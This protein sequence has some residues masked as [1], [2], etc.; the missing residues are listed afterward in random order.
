MRPLPTALS[1]L[2]LAAAGLVFAASARTSPVQPT[3]PAAGEPKESEKGRSQPRTAAD[4]GKSLMEG[5]KATPGCLGVETAQTMS[6]KVVIFT[7]FEN[8]KAV[9]AWYDSPAHKRVMRAFFPDRDGPDV[10]MKDIAED[11][12]PILAVASLMPAD[13]PLP[14]SNAPISQIS[15]ELYSPLPGG[16]RVNGGFAPEA[17]KVPGRID[18]DTSIRQDGPPM[19]PPNKGK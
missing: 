7:W 17:L 15:I 18:V 16:I 3:A 1:I 12:G 11:S 14:G 13:K 4:I 9:M 8:K 10:P 19:A 2:S 5:L 6:G